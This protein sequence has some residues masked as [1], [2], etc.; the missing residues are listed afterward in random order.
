MKRF[1][2]VVLTA[3]ALL[4]AAALADR[5]ETGIVEYQENIRGVGLMP[6]WQTGACETRSTS[7][8]GMVCLDRT[9]GVLYWFNGSSFVALNSTLPADAQLVVAYNPSATT[10]AQ[11]SIKVTVTGHAANEKTFA[12]SDGTFTVDKEGDAVVASLTTAGAA[13][14]GALTVT[15]A[16]SATTSVTGNTLVATTSAT[17]ATVVANTSL[18]IAGGTAIT[19]SLAVSGALNFGSIAAGECAEL[20]QALV[21]AAVNDPVACAQPAAIEDRLIV[22]CRVSAT[23]VVTQRVCNDNLV[24]AIDPASATFGARLIR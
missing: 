4:P 11:S 18:T 22:S 15:G 13:A 10:A 12:N 6:P 1:A 17:A 23:D 14:T 21:G 3:L 5:V 20:T 8:L 19:A 7:R 24:A 2:V 9:N 16:A